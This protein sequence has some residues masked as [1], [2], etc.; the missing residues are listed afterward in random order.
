MNDAIPP[1]ASRPVWFPGWGEALARANL[2]A[3]TRTAYRT[4]VCHYLRFCKATRQREG[5]GSWYCSHRGIHATVSRA[6]LTR[7]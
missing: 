2:P 4:A 7:L 5:V 1:S 3:A 6:L